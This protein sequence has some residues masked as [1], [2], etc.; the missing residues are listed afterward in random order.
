MGGRAI[1]AT[2]GLGAVLVASTGCAR[3]FSSRMERARVTGAADRYPAVKQLSTYYAL[4]LAVAGEPP[5]EMR[6]S[7]DPLALRLLELWDIPRYVIYRIEGVADSAVGTQRIEGQSDRVYPISMAAWR[8]L[9]QALTD[10][11]VWNAS[12]VGAPG[13]LDAEIYGLEIRQG[14]RHRILWLPPPHYENANATL[15]DLEAAIYAAMG[16]VRTSE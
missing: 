6:D 3:S 12:W 16:L 11:D 13:V 15:L 2:L 10:V 8:T 7:A 9:Q 14:L 5:F 4:N 1:V